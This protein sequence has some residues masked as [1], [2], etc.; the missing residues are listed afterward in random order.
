MCRVGR[1]G[2]VSDAQPP[3]LGSCRDELTEGGGGGTTALVASTPEPCR[4]DA[5]SSS[6]GDCLPKPVGSMLPALSRSGVTPG[7]PGRGSRVPP[8]SASVISWP[9]P[10]SL[11]PRF[12]LLVGTP[13]VG[14]G[15]PSDLDVGRDAVS[16]G[17]GHTHTCPMG[18]AVLSKTVPDAPGRGT[19]TGRWLGLQEGAEAPGRIMGG[20]VGSR[21]RGPERL[22]PP[23]SAPCA[24][25]HDAGSCLAQTNSGRLSRGPC[26]T[27]GRQPSWA[28]PQAVGKP[29]THH[30]GSSG[31][32]VPGFYLTTFVSL[33]KP[34]RQVR[35]SP[36]RGRFMTSTE[37]ATPP[38]TYSDCQ[39]RRAQCWP[40]AP[41]APSWNGRCSLDPFKSCVLGCSKQ[42]CIF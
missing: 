25:A 39:S 16:L 5:L 38:L 1:R 40:L 10:L 28:G 12:P 34:Q 36:S 17:Q 2:L 32:L 20:P 6:V 41:G 13:L 9:S 21:E 22:W 42:I 7:V 23:R 30:H 3:L 37:L 4:W 15:R 24:R 26:P 29:P 14:S 31:A 11:R 33:Q 18:G 19:S 35:H 8:A 27:L